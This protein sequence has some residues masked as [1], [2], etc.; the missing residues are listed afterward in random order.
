[1]VSPVISCVLRWNYRNPRERATATGLLCT[2]C[3]C[4]RLAGHRRPVVP[5][6]A[7]EALL[8]DLAGGKGKDDGRGVRRFGAEGNAVLEQKAHHGHE[9]DALVAIDEG[10]I[11]R[12]PKGIGSRRFSHLRLFVT[13]FIDRTLKG[14]SQHSFL[15][16]ARSSTKAAQLAAMDCDGL[17]V[18]DP[19]RL[20]RLA[21]GNA[22]R[23]I[24]RAPRACPCTCP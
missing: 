11:F 16:Q 17:L 19:E 6:P 21:H 2:S 18:S 14:R 7:G 1:M 13:P 22:R 5:D 24:W 8:A 4:E 3:D 9:G 10:V 20:I 12:E 23:S 15:A